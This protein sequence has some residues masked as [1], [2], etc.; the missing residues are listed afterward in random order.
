VAQTTLPAASA[1]TASNNFFNSNPP[2]RVA[3]PPF[4]S[5]TALQNG[6]AANTVFWYT[7]ENGATPARQTAIALVGPST[8]I[9]YGMRANEQAIGAL[10]A[11]VAALATT[12]Y[13]PANA[14]AAVSY[15]ALTQ[16]VGANL[17]PQQ[18]AQNFTDIVVDIANAKTA[19]QNADAVNQQTKSTL[20]DMLQKIEGVSTDQ[21]GAQILAVQTSLQASL[22]TTARL[23][24][25][26]LVNYLSG[27]G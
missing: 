10:V 22:S 17:S 2:Q 3:G 23:S 16:R 7:G 8:Q 20:T 25:L 19:A 4:N 14:N 21:I 12:T 9:S 6:T 13:A 27:T 11:N 18:G 1:I 26:S 15:S 5:A 24:Q